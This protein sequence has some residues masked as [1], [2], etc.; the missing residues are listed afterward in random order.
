MLFQREF[1][2]NNSDHFRHCDEYNVL[3]FDCEW[4]IDQYGVRQNVS[5]LQLASHRGLCVLVRLCEFGKIPSE[6]QVDLKFNKNNE[7]NVFLPD[8]K[9]LFGIDFFR[10]Y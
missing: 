6:L 1:H 5:L 8:S 2:A 7:S 10:K 4:V 3:G 9:W